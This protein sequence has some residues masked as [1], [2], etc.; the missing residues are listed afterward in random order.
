MGNFSGKEVGEGSAKAMTADD[1]IFQVNFMREIFQIIPKERKSFEKATMVVSLI[2]FFWEKVNINPGI[3]W[4][5][6]TLE[7][8]E[9]E[10][11]DFGAKKELRLIFF[12]SDELAIGREVCS[13]FFFRKVGEVAEVDSPPG[14]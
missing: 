3:L 5:R 12:K 14:H 7:R 4:C 6:R 2:I 1:E 11:F 9:V 13:N 8:E 10:V